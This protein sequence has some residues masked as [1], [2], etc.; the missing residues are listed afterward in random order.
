MFSDFFSLFIHLFIF[1]A[2]IL[3]CSL[4][5]PGTALLQSANASTTGSLAL[6]VFHTFMCYVLKVF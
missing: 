4:D 6:S 5:G 1:K 2:N 3:P